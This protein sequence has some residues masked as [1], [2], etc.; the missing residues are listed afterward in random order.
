[1]MFTDFSLLH[2]YL[3]G[4]EYELCSQQVE[5]WACYKIY[6]SNLLTFLKAKVILS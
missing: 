2:I 1:M 3:F 4:K 5:K 6:L